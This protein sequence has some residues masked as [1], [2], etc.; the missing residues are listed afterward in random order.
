VQYG[1]DGAEKGSAGLG[2]S[3][4]K[5]IVEAHGGRIFVESNNS[6]GSK[7]IVEIPAAVES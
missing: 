4:V 1:S 2:L 6:H 5:E 3:I 7:F